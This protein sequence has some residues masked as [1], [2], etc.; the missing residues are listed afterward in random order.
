MVDFLNL[1]DFNG[2]VFFE[3][4][5]AHGIRRTSLVPVIQKDGVGP[6]CLAHFAETVR[7]Q[8][9]EGLLQCPREE[10]SY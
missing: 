7:P 8:W 9:R 2:I 3:I 4:S 10:A 1:F 6:W 5:V